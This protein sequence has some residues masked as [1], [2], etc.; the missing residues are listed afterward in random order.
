VDTQQILVVTT[1]PNRFEL[2]RQ[3][4]YNW[5]DPAE[6]LDVALERTVDEAILYAS[7]RQVDLVVVDVVTS[8]ARDPVVIH[9]VIALFTPV[10]VV[11]WLAEQDSK[12]SR[13]L[14]AQGATACLN[15]SMMASGLLSQTFDII[16][17]GAKAQQLR[18]QRMRQMSVTLEAIADA[19]IC[20]DSRAD[21]TYVNSAARRLLNFPSDELI[22]CTVTKV[23]TL[24][25]HQSRELITH[26]VHHVVSNMQTNRVVPGTVLVR[27]DGSEI[28]IADCCSPIIDLSG[29]LQGTVMVFHDIT[30]A[31]EMQAQI[32]HLAWHDFL[33]GLPNRFAIHKRIE[34][35]LAHATVHH[36]SV[37]LLYLD[38]D[39]FKLVNDTL[40]HGAGDKLLVSVAE[41]LG[42]C[43]RLADL[44][45]RQGG[46]EFVVVMAPGS[47]SEDAVL[48]GARILEA[49]GKPH[50]INGS[51]V[52]TR[53]S[54]GIATFP[55]HANTAETLMLNA[56]AA[57]QSV[58]STGRNGCRIFSPD[59]LADTLE[60]QLMEKALR[61]AIKDGGFSLFYQPKVKL[62]NETVCG[63]EALLRW[64]HRE[65]GWVPPTKFIPCAEASGLIEVLGKW[66]LDEAIRQAQAWKKAEIDFGHIAINI[67]TQELRHPGFID[68]VKA[69]LNM[70]SIDTNTLQFELTESVLMHDIDY[71]SK[72][73]RELKQ[74]G[75][76][77]AIDDFGTGYSSLSYL[78]GLR[79]DVV[80]IDR[81]FIHGIHRADT[82]QQALFHAILSLAASQ[83]LSVVI[84]GIETFDEMHYLRKH[85]CETGQGYYF[86]EPLE[87]GRF[88]QLLRLGS[89]A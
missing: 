39:K 52:R 45:G 19:V 18:D 5:L 53:C 2:L 35:T 15:D 14:V 28:R 27:H 22:G 64:R 62:A 70:S 24:Q 9:P 68:H 54:I 87:A 4:L 66:V 32:D 69:R 49:L 81:S 23:M 89:I 80:K 65:W 37:P 74:L 86:S 31:Y 8:M 12:L 21:I 6:R 88:E 78:N 42:A 71:A 36:Q 82:R 57:L 75:L 76:S 73:L 43:F 56:D 44:V 3:L 13:D 11:A 59:L 25:D 26:P 40:G 48:A 67:S 16:V 55:E 17:R 38:L 20:T 33:T 46:D 77:V 84:E 83:S 41:R 58:K 72:V 30:E 50:M 63:C 1:D 10:P 79:L 85:G 51:E 29:A 47:K 7:R 34:D 60:R 61:R